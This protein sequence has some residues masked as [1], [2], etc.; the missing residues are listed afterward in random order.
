MLFCLASHQDIVKIM[1]KH[2]MIFCVHISLTNFYCFTI[3]LIEASRYKNGTY[4]AMINAQI[5][6][7]E[8]PCDAILCMGQVNLHVHIYSLLQLLA[9]CLSTNLPR[10]LEICIL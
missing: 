2:E 10:Q 8:N 3:H 5:G 4:Q 7:V 6:F 1:S 9:F